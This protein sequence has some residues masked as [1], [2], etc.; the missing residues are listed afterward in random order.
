MSASDAKRT[1]TSD[2]D[3]EPPLCLLDLAQRRVRAA[4]LPTDEHLG[5]AAR[6]SSTV[7][8]ARVLR[9]KFEQRRVSRTRRALDPA[10]RR[11]AEG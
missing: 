11:M 1:K 4:A 5:G 2:D 6:G 8:A 9:R 7:G 10:L 3:C